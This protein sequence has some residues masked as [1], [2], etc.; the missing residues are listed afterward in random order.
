MFVAL[1]QSACALVPKTQAI[2]GAVEQGT[3]EGADKASGFH[4]TVPASHSGPY[5]SVDVL[6]FQTG[7]SD[8]A[9]QDMTAVMGKSRA[10]GD[11]EVLVLLKREKSQW[12]PLPKKVN[13]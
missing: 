2:Q 5:T 10:T 3:F 13:H 9:N 11:W 12:I 4:V 1:L 7:E 6:N 8:S